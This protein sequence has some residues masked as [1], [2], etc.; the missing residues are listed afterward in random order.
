MNLINFRSHYVTFLT[1]LCC[2]S[3]ETFAHSKFY[4]NL[5]KTTNFAGENVEHEPAAAPDTVNNHR[6]P[7][8]L[9][10]SNGANTDRIFRAIWDLPNSCKERFGI[11]L[12]LSDFGIE[13]NS[14]HQGTGGNVINLF[15]S[16][17]LGLYPRYEYAAGSKST[18]STPIPIN[19]GLPQLA[20]ITQHLEKSAADIMSTIP[21]PNFDGVSVIDWEAWRPQWH[22]N[23]DTLAVYQ[24]ESIAHVKKMHPEWDNATVELV[25]KLEWT[26]GAKL[27][28]ESTLKLGTTLR[29]KASWG[30]YAYPYCFN[31]KETA[32]MSCTATAVATNNDVMWL[33][34]ESSSLYPSIYLRPTHTNQ[35]AYVKSKLE[36][37][38]RVRDRSGDPQGVVFSYTRFNYSH[39]GFFYSLENL[40]DTILQS[41]ELGVDG[42]IFWGDNFDDKSAEACS[43][44][45]SYIKS[46][47]GPTVRMSQEGA[48]SCSKRICSGKGRCV[49]DI[50][51][52]GGTRRLP[53]GARRKGTEEGDRGG[54]VCTCRCFRG[55]TGKDCSVPVKEKLN[56]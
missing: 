43:H 49:G 8:K 19:G 20:N 40:N 27:F 55:W 48:E 5:M 30:Y 51:K 22:D 26:E 32:N 1:I 7:P 17:E 24:Q 23:F 3:I 34:N 18:K 35:K 15:Y 54:N 9:R 10:G 50:L 14:N 42:V 31:N 25:A 44:L 4:V 45:Q 38:F 16:N 53:A 39:T 46:A 47:L 41:A 52:C 28:M 13:F 11:E 12:P 37:A 36:E 6:P 21:D 2:A 56:N 29:P 33:F